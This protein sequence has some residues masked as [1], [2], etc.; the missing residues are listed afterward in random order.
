MIEKLTPAPSYTPQEARNGRQ[1]G[2]GEHPL[3][4]YLK[5]GR[6]PHIWC[7]GCG[8]GI[9]LNAFV[10]ALAKSGLERDNTVVVSGIGCCGRAAGYLAFDT[11]HTT[12][13]RAIAFATGMK[14]A[15]PKLNVVVISGDGDLF[16]IGGNHLIHAARRNVDLTVLCVNNF[17]YGMTG[18]QSGPTTPISGI[19]ST[20]PYGSPEHPFSL[21]YLAKAAG[22][23][24]VARWTALHTYELRDA[25]VEA[26]GKPGFS[27]IE[28]I[29]PC[30][31]AHGRRNKLGAGIDLLRFY[32]DHSYVTDEIDPADSGLGLTGRIAVGKFV[33]IRKATFSELYQ[34]H[35]LSKARASERK[36][37]GGGHP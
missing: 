9:V 31:T 33:D 17:N 36:A 7:A 14:L 1:P 6:I 12:H 35:V 29:S 21:V 16:A 32:R 3:D 10:R 26:M 13:G 24:Y 4:A 8:N 28:T 15:N 22:A 30:P 37:P 19:T 5:D 25:I 34:E 23:T 20:T 11:Y 18:G 27:F 2:H